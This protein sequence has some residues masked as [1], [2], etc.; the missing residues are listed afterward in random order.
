MYLGSDIQPKSPASG[1]HHLDLY[2]VTPRIGVNTA[3]AN[4]QV[5]TCRVADPHLGMGLDDNSA[6][7]ASVAVFHPG[8]IDLGFPAT[9]I[10][11]KITFARPGT[12]RIEGADVSYSDGTRHAVQHAGSGTVIGVVSAIN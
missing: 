7:G 3:H 12:V 2:R 10:V 1:H 4:V 5:L 8:T 11:Y 6:P 9:E